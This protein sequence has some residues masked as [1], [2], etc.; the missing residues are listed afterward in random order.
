M[1]L[2]AS[3]SDTEIREVSGL[4]S[5]L[6]ELKLNASFILTKDVSETLKVDGFTV[7]FKSLIDWLIEE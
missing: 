2:I 3:G 6:E 7:R 4:I 1:Q 5:C